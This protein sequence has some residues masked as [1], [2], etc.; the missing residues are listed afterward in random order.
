MTSNVFIP[1]KCRGKERDRSQLSSRRYCTY[2]VGFSV[3]KK[4]LKTK[5]IT[6]DH[7]DNGSVLVYAPEVG[8]ELVHEAAQTADHVQCESGSADLV[9]RHNII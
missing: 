6:L 7:F 4:F 9:Q 3:C 1:E 8:P 2:C 5:Y